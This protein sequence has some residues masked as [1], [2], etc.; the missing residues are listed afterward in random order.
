M[1]ERRRWAPVA[2]CL[3]CV[4]C[5]GTHTVEPGHAKDGSHAL[6]RQDPERDITLVLSINFDSQGGL[7]KDLDQSSVWEADGTLAGD[8]LELKAHGARY[9]CAQE[10]AMRPIVAEA[11]YDLGPRTK[12][13]SKLHLPQ[14]RTQVQSLCGEKVGTIQ[15]SGQEKLEAGSSDLGRQ[16][17][18]AEEQTSGSEPELEGFARKRSERS[19]QSWVLTDLHRRVV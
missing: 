15:H 4:V 16:C 8:L 7:V 1:E 12:R 6:E 14:D 3:V 9:V 18:S 11:I 13:G 10:F 2:Y 19:R 5:D 17:V